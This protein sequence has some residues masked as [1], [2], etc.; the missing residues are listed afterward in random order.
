MRNLFVRRQ[1]ICF[2]FAGAVL[3]SVIVLLAVIAASR[4]RLV[5]PDSTYFLRD[6]HGRFL[7]EAGAPPDG[8][9]GYWELAAPPPRVMTATLAV[10]DR[11]FRDHP[12]VDV[13]AIVRAM[14][15]NAIHLKRSSGAST[16]AMQVSR[17]QNPGS[18]GYLRKAVEALTALILTARR[19]RED[20]LRHYLRIVPYGNRVHGIAYA[21]RRYFDKPV[22]DLS[23]AETAFLTA[24]PQAPNHMNPFTGEGKR[25]AA[26]RGKRILDI[27][28][29]DKAMSREE[30]E[31][32]C[33]QISDL[34][35][36]RPGIRPEQAMHA[37][38][39][40]DQI[41]K[42][43]SARL[44]PQAG[45]LV[46]TTLDLDLQ[47][48]M[49][50]LVYETVRK[51]DASGARN[52][53]AIIVDRESNEIR[54]WIGSTD[55]FDENHSGAIDYAA[56][57]RSP[58]SALK[59]FFYAFALESREITPSTILDDLQRG[60]GG[61]VNADALFMGPVLPRIAL[62]NSR[63]VPAAALLEKIG[64]EKGYDFLRTLGLH[65]GI[66]PA[67][68][69]GV[70]MSIGNLPVTLEKLVQAYSVLSRE[71]RLDNLLWFEGQVKPVSRRV[72][73]ENTTRQL[74]LFLSDPL[75]RMPG[76]SRMGALEFP[77]PVAIKTGTSSRFRDAWALA[78]S[79]R[80][81]V[82]VW[83]G[84]PDFQ[85]MNHLT[86]STSA[87][88]LVKNILLTLH[89]DQRAGLHDLSFPPPRGFKAAR[90][91]ALTGDLATDACDRVSL[92]WF[93]PTEH[94]VNHCRAH[95]RIAADMRTGG[96]A[97]SATPREFITVKTFVDLPPRYAEWAKAAGLSEPPKRPDD[98]ALFAPGP[99][100]TPLMPRGKKIQVSIISPE[101]GLSL[102]RDPET[103]EEQS[104]L[105]LR[106]VVD[107]VVPQLV[108]YVD[109]KPFKVAD[110]PYTVRL[111]LT[112][113]E[114]TI[115]A[116]LPDAPF[117]SKPVRIIVQ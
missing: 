53:A 42:D 16:I 71:G 85:P 51:W 111:T 48:A 88:E 36:P 29:R 21:A 68:R 115:Q 116:R 25:R 91:C 66:E 95:V 56:V 24:I 87:A 98:L 84:D 96:Q 43:R 83:V 27:L 109:G 60:P 90:I 105:A 107:P 73:S 15:Q 114:R 69:Y 30:Y 5:S 81:L 17:M 76:F 10:E 39:R 74:A 31:L 32:A 28:Y 9:Y 72:L 6:R 67:S 77:F 12:G 1:F 50:G 89:A 108:W 64:I 55:Y 110:Y 59:P 54:S 79:V 19:S 100:E 4:A 41:L 33:F 18:R 40:M 65:N 113:G 57:P 49:S 38:L 11:R 86:G 106:A 22:D 99:E 101:N 75:G 102:I 61:I 8:E 52:A 46:T 112:S 62:A 20:I 63:N 58:G 2:A 92:E 82:G 80:Y 44:S 3:S 97:S 47:N 103:P 26:L 14:C 23:W 78:F 7:G 94:P 13:L 37:L 35:V 104:T 93:R 117:S 70:G 45:R 34:P